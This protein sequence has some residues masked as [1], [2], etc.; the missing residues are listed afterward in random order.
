MIQTGS[1]TSSVAGAVGNTPVLR[2]EFGSEKLALYAKCEFRNPSGSHKDRFALAVVENAEKRGL[3]GP[4]RVILECSNG[5][6]GVA[7]AMIGAARG[8][9]VTIAMPRTASIERQRQIEDMGGEV[10][11]FD[12]TGS[13][14]G[15]KMI[16][17][18]AAKD[19]RYYL[20]CQY[21]NP[22][23]I[24]V[25]EFGTGDEI[26]KQVDSPIDALV[27]AYG[28]GATAAGVSRS[29]RWRDP[30]MQV[31]LVEH[32]EDGTPLGEGICSQHPRCVADSFLPPILVCFRPTGIIKVPGI[33]AIRMAQRLYRQFGL[34]VGTF[35]GASVVASL[36]VARN[37]GPNARI[38]TLLCDRTQV[39]RVFRPTDDAP[40]ARIEAI[41]TDDASVVT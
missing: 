40:S 27:V 29:L 23:G 14:K 13:W 16:R 21:S 28:T 12:G 10:V 17:E 18:M 20:P 7:L 41:G 2:L 31:Y 1:S 6:T 4:G 8:H 9:K 39:S 34:A 35:S 22:L 25:N 36:Q 26:L 30:S 3:L 19:P 33:E 11:I 5:S 15:L 37:L 32:T 24:A 38:V